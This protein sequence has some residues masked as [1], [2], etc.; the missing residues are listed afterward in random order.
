MLEFN[1]EAMSTA[2]AAACVTEA[3]YSVDPRA[4]LQ[5][6]LEGREVRVASTQANARFV[7]ALEAA[8]YR[9]LE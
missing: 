8:G 5:I 4:V 1:I 2:R 7:A 6:D 3:V 9:P